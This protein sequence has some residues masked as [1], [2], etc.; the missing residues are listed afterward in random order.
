MEVDYGVGGGV[1]GVLR[2]TGVT[3]MANTNDKR[4]K[5]HLILRDGNLGSLGLA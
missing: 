3:G 1:D 5:T 4:Q 2:A